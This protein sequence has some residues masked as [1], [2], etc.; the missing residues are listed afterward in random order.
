M[1][2]PRLTSP[3]GLVTAMLLGVLSLGV[4][5]E[6]AAGQRPGSGAELT[7]VVG[8]VEVLRTTAT[9]WAP[10]VVGARLAEGDDLRAFAGA[11]AELTLPDASVVTLAENSRMHVTKL[12]IDTQQQSRLVLLHLAVGKLRA[13]IAQAGITLVRARQSNFAIST[14]TAVAAARGTIVWVAHDQNTFV[15]VEPQP[16]LQ[17][18][19][20]IEC[21]T[22]G[23]TNQKRQL[24]M[25]GSFSAEC[26]PPVPVQIQFLS[27]S[28]LATANAN[29]GG[30]VV[31]PSTAAV[32][33][34]VT[35]TPPAA[36]PTSGPGPAAGTP[37]PVAGLP[38][39]SSLGV[40]Q[41]VNPPPPA[42]A[43]NPC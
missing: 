10:A 34:L 28:N 16:G 4:L 14:P 13:V 2:M 43:T 5:P 22:L 8:R 1:R 39:P 9:Q 36:G 35:S 41:T 30:S 25:A 27:L 19:S 37:N 29:L 42:C 33:A 40:N 32:L 15:A 17:T 31:L 23:P 21:I 38:G 24:V 20:R 3:S 12:E 18:P 7:R 26:S 11:W 6:P